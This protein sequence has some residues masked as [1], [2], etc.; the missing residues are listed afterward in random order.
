MSIVCA[1]YTSVSDG[2]CSSADKDPVVFGFNKTSGCLLPVSLQNLTQCN[3]L[4]SAAQH[5]H[6]Y[7]RKMHV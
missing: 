2:M 7:L 5:E 6:V 3:L 4:R 1:L